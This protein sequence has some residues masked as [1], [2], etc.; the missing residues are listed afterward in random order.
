MIAD[1]ECRL[2]DI[3]GEETECVLIRRFTSDSSPSMIFDAPVHCPDA[4]RHR[5]LPAR[6]E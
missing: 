5:N 1:V 4:G 2:C 3:S 6:L